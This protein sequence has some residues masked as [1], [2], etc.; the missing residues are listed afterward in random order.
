V[1]GLAL[2]LAACSSNPCKVG[3]QDYL[4]AR[5]RPRLQMPQ[6]VSGSERLGGSVLVIP[7]V[8]PTPDK[9]D[10]AP[11]CLDDPPNFFRRVGGAVAGSPEEAVNV[12][13]MAWAG[14][15]ADQV[16][17]FYSPNFQSPEGGGASAYIEQRRQ[18]VASGKAPDPR[19]DELKTT[20]QGND[21][22]VVTFVQHFGD[23]AVRKELTLQRD[24]QGWRIVAERTLEVL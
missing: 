5:E 2:G 1:A 20:T 19:L 7:P 10:P 14:R 18:Q 3:N 23:N 12:W 9:L 16:A 15:K 11:R 21:R 17:S 4:T 24:P 8:S 22:A 13:A 6:G